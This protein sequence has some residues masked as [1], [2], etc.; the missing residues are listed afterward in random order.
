MAES[1]LLDIAGDCPCKGHGNILLQR[2]WDVTNGWDA[3]AKKLVEGEGVR[4]HQ[5]CIK[6]ATGMY[7]N[8]VA[9]FRDD[10]GHCRDS[11]GM[12][13]ITIPIIWGCAV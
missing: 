12:S 9:M 7:V 1:R 10:V 3:R 2:R 8:A 5:L 4:E 6:W 13:E 11:L